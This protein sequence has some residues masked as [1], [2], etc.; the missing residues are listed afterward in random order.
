M[1]HMK[2]K[3]SNSLSN[4]C[5]PNTLEGEIRGIYEYETKNVWECSVCGR[6]WID[7]DDHEVKGCHISKSYMPEDGKIGNLFSVGTSEEFFK[8]LESWWK[9]H[10]DDLK[11]LGIIQDKEPILHKCIQDYHKKLCEALDKIEELEEKMRG[12]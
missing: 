8:Y 11:K 6:L 7:V 4:V 9:F 12:M 2:C 3:C 10:G 1:A 5:C